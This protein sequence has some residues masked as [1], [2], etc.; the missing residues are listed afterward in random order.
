MYDRAG[1]SN[2]EG[3]AHAVPHGGLCHMEEGAS[4][5]ICLPEGEIYKSPH[6]TRVDIL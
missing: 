4:L 1:C 3:P 6:P 2:P 5:I